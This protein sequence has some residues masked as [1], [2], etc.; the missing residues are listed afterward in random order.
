MSF[1]TDSQNECAAII[2]EVG[3]IAYLRRANINRACVAA[4]IESFARDE[5]GQLMNPRSKII[6]ISALNLDV[7]P[8][9]QIDSYI[10]FSGQERRMTAPQT[11]V[12]PAGVPAYWE[13]RVLA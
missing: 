7:P 8:D 10:D 12:A 13:I 3:G 6:L 4:D 11:S 5:S 9:W 1:H 2:A